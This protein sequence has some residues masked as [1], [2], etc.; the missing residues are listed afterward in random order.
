MHDTTYQKLH[1]I[2]PTDDEQLA[3]SKHV[4]DTVKNKTQKLHLV[5][6]II[7]KGNYLAR[8]GQGIYRKYYTYILL[9]GL[10]KNWCNLSQDTRCLDEIWA[11]TSLVNV[12]GVTTTTL[13]STTRLHLYT[14]IIKPVEKRVLGKLRFSAGKE[15]PYIL[16]NP[17][18]YYIIYKGP[19]FVPVLIQINPVH[20]LPTYSIKI[21]SN[22][23]F[24]SAPGIPQ[25][26][27]S[28]RYS[29]QNPLSTSPFPHT[30]HVPN[31][32]N[33]YLFDCQYTF[34]WGL[35]IIKFPVYA[36]STEIV[37]QRDV[38]RVFTNE[39]CSFKS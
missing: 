7:S 26:S 29:H 5:G 38:Y 36:P 31:P 11:E 27:L 39:W 2:L 16:R 24:L 23:I 15:I 17:N 18:S 4:E 13:R 12:R 25:W 35:N 6:S 22:I 37:I 3:C 34:Y 33:S 19:P 28:L 14:E 8:S 20:S 9:E 1:V 32:S 21:R 10:S 30:C